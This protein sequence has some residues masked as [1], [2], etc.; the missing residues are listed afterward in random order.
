MKLVRLN[1]QREQLRIP[2]RVKKNFATFHV[3]L[4]TFPFLVAGMAA[5]CADSMTEVGK[6]KEPID[7]TLQSVLDFG[8][9]LRSVK[10]MGE[11]Y[12]VQGDMMFHKS[13]ST[14]ESVLDPGIQ[15][16]QYM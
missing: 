6:D 8:Y 11:Y 15:Q 7:P 13:A 3:F 4:R 14:V 5:G 12:L 2:V 16:Q 10:D 1:V 9:S